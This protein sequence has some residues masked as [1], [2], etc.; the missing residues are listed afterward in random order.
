MT[1]KN[2]TNLSFITS[3]TG[4]GIKVLS[5]LVIGNSNVPL[6]SQCQMGSLSVFGDVAKSSFTLRRVF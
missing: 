3:I 5:H 1:F 2:A 6:P 4:L